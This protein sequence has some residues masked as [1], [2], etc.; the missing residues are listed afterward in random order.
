MATTTTWQLMSTVW[1][2]WMLSILTWPLNSHWSKLFECRL[3]ARCHIHAHNYTHFKLYVNEPVCIQLPMLADN[4]TLFAFA[5][6]CHA[7]GCLAGQAVDRHLLP[8]GLTAA[9]PPQQ[10][11]AAKRWDG[12]YCLATRGPAANPSHAAAAVDRWDGQTD[13]W[14]PYWYT[15]PATFCASSVDNLY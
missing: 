1:I 13:R 2:S 9:N 5:A 14:T 8:A 11:T 10:H 7:D 4:V 12:W 3:Q 15:D 6:E